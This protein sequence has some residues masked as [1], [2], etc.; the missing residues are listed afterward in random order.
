MLK[1]SIFQAFG[2]IL[3]LVLPFVPKRISSGRRWAAP[4]DG[5]PFLG[6]AFLLN[7]QSNWQ[8]FWKFSFLLVESW[9][10]WLL[11]SVQILFES[12]VKFGNFLAFGNNLLGFGCVFSSAQILLEKVLKNWNL[13][14]LVESGFWLLC[15]AFQIL[16]ETVLKIIQDFGRILILV[17]VFFCPNSTWKSVEN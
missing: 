1:N 6:I 7:F 8:K 4:T 10:R 15:F 12:V 2:R 5:I 11:F 9:F 14:L 3:V 16:L 13:Q 17:V